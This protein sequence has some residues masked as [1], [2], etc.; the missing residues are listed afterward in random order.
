MSPETTDVSPTAPDEAE[1]PP[2]ET[3][4]PPAEAEAP[5]RERGFLAGIGLA[6]SWGALLVVAA[7]AV[8]AIIVPNVTGSTPLAILTGSM[9]PAYPPGT[10]VVV[11]PVDPAEVRVGDVITYQLESGKPTL[12]THR[13]IELGL[14]ADG[15]RQWVTQ[16][17]ANVVA[18]E[19]PVRAVQLRGRVW[20]HVPY[21]G[22]VTTALGNG[23]RGT[24][25]ALVAGGFIAYGV[26]QITS[27]LLGRGRR[28]KASA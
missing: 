3:D 26:W 14:R 23:A 15:E 21:L 22:H 11:K 10:L 16:G 5:P 6:L 19:K 9:T 8:V 4:V 28:E 20:Y 25:V 13:V 17:D 27:G 1:V 2:A 18:D 7:I 12:V 24:V